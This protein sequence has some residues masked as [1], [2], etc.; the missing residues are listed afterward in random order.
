MDAKAKVG[1]PGWVPALKAQTRLMAE[2]S[3]KFEA[4]E[5]VQLTPEQIAVIETYMQ[6][7]EA[8]S[9]DLGM[10]NLRHH[11]QLQSLIS[12]LEA[13]AGEWMK[14]PLGSYDF[15]QGHGEATRE[16]GREIRDLLADHRV[17]I[18]AAANTES[19][20]GHAR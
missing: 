6:E 3:A 11:E 14:E 13:L 5:S 2:L 12:G 1:N 19:E 15:D 16:C 10:L 18:P 20:E 4:G 9:T 17:L 7:D 8:L